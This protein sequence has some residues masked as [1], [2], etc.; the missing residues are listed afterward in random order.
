MD[1][2]GG[3][4]EMA[5]TSEFKGV[6]GCEISK[7]AN[8]KFDKLMGD[9]NI[10]DVI[11]EQQ[12]RPKLDPVERENKFSKL[13]DIGDFFKKETAET[14]QKSDP[15]E[16]MTDNKS[17]AKEQLSDRTEDA[18]QE[19][20]Y[21]EK[22]EPNSTYEFNGNTYETDDNGQ[23]YK[24]NGEILPN[25]EYTVNGNTYKTDERGNKVSCDS[26]PEYTE[27]GSRN[28]KEQKE[29]GGEER[30]DD[31]DGGHIIA[32]ILGGAEGEENLVPMR[33]T[34]NRGD[35][36]R[37]ENEISKALQE[38]KKVTMHIDI[39]YDGDS[40][41]PSKIRVEYTIDGKKTVCEFD[42]VEGSTDLLDSLSDKISDED[43]GRLKQI[44]EEM[45]EDGCD[46]TITSVKVEY[47]EN[48]NPTKVTVGILDE[49][50]GTKKYKEYSPR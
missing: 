37:M 6:E 47:D 49:S 10:K 15:T 27:D 30:Q 24:K 29:S 14:E 11:P 8:D 3:L 48:G 9:D 21:S 32:R 34:I 25:I 19:S 35:Y 4:S 50:I 45:K 38:G 22:R 36:K 40:S 18:N 20:D 39:E 5:E 28:M 1:F 16:G 2:L 42:N 41:R 33:R 23:T 31:D 7:E 13:F 17:D 46:A 12:N 43:C 44:L 26:T